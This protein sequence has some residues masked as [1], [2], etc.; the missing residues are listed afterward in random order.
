VYSE[1]PSSVI[2]Y[3]SIALD[4]PIGK[5]QLEPVASN[6]ISSWSV[7]LKRFIV[8]SQPDAIHLDVT[9]DLTISWGRWPDCVNSRGSLFIVMGHLAYLC[10][11]CSV[12]LGRWLDYVRCRGSGGPNL[13]IVA[14]RFA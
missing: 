14:G 11:F 9:V 7:S 1:L 10:L 6:Y 4:M 2:G 13:F 3:N 8:A 5:R 12:S